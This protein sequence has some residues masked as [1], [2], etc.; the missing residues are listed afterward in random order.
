MKFQFA[1]LFSLLF[2]FKVFALETVDY[3]DVERYMGNWFELAKYPNSFQKNCEKAQANYK[4]KDNGEVEVINTCIKDNK[5]EKV[6]KARAWI[7]DEATN[8]KL[9]VQ[10]F[11]KFFKLPIFAGDYWVIMLGDDYEYAVVSEPKKE[12]LWILSRTKK[13]EASKLKYIKDSLKDK[14]F[15]LSKLVFEKY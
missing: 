11:A 10:F 3:V 4:L 2:T 5:K 6:A 1:F 13:L 14:G 9:K 8:A 7:V 15:D 12:F